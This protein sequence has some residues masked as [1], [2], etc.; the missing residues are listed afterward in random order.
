[1]A[2]SISGNL[3]KSNLYSKSYANLFN[4]INNKNNITDPLNDNSTRKFVYSREPDVTNINFQGYPFIIIKPAVIN[5]D[6]FTLD[7]GSSKKEF[8]FEIEIRCT[9][10]VKKKEGSGEY[11]IGI[12]YL[13]EITDNLI[14]TLLDKNN[15]KILHSYGMGTFDIDTDSADSDEIEGDLVWIRRITLTSSERLRTGS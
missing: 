2:V 6:M 3:T 12:Q 4:L 5:V 8:L 11:N 9:D 14:K 13:D 7:S 1:M 15:R 10:R